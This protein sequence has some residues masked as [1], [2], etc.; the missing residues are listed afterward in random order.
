METRSSSDTSSWPDWLAMASRTAHV[1]V[2]VS[3]LDSGL[4]VEVNDS[5]CRLFQL[6]REQIIG[7]SSSALGMWPEPQQRVRL[8]EAARRLGGVTRFEARYRNSAGEIGELEISARVVQQGDETFLIGFLTDVTDQREIVEGLRA[9]QSRLDIVLRA[10]NMLVFRQDTELRYTWVANPVLGASE[11]EVIGRTDDELLGAEAAAPLREIKR[12]VLETGVAERR[13]VWVTNN[14]QSGCFDLIV[15]PE[16]DAAGRLIGI[17]CAAHDITRRMTARRKALR[18]PVSTIRGMCSL[19]GQETLTPRQADRLRHL[20]LTA[21]GLAPPPHPA[22]AFERLRQHHAGTLVVV[23]EQNPVVSELLC[24]LLEL[25]GL[26]VAAARTG[27]EAFSFSLQLAP[28]LLLLDM[29][30]PQG[31]AVAAARSLRTMAPNPLPI[32]A[33]LSGSPIGGAGR[34]LDADLDDVL[35]KPVTA[36]SLYDKVLAWLEAR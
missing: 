20:D 32:V 6:T 34:A 18:L 23:A 11:N 25:A 29:E 5:F 19:I 33:M 13:D 35:D 4:F 21:G 3:S 9:A 27:V 2:G 16:R 12:R 8:V 36:A 15:E 7:H 14:G 1:A 26:R 17:V 22:P 30:M 28:A 24:A 10:S 31:G